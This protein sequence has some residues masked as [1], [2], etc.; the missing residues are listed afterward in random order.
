[1][2]IMKVQNSIENA[3][4]RSNSIG[5][6]LQKVSKLDLGDNGIT[7]LEGLPTMEELEADDDIIGEFEDD[8][9]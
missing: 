1:Q 2:R 4:K 9:D 8:N 7:M 3:E 5:T 6:K